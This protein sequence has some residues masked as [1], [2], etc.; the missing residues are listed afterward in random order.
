MTAIRQINEQDTLYDFS[1]NKHVLLFKSD[2]QARADSA[3]FAQQDSIITLFKNPVLWTDSIQL[4]ADTIKIYLEK[5]GI[6]KVE[7]RQNCFFIQWVEQSLYNQLKG[8]EIDAYFLNNKIDSLYAN[9]N[10][11]TIFMV[12]DEDSTY[13]AIDKMK[14]GKMDVNFNENKIDEIFWYNQQE[15]TTYPFQKSNPDEFKLSGFAWREDERPKSVDDLLIAIGRKEGTFKFKDSLD[16]QGSEEAIGHEND[17][18]PKAFENRGLQ[19]GKEID[20]P[21]KIPK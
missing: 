6:K 15:G 7:F 4:S 13:V 18:S 17:L 12:Q 11:E 14:S 19:P 16:T 9:G 3:Y 21:P 1:A 8:R 5:E 20:D 10:A 2:I